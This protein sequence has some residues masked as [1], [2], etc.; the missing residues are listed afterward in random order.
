[1]WAGAW[2]LL[3]YNLIVYKRVWKGTA[4]TSFVTPLL[5]VV[6]MGVLLGGFVHVAPARLD[7]AP[8]YLAFIAPGLVASHAMTIAFSEMTYPVMGMVKWQK[9]YFS[10]IATPLSVPDL[11]LAHLAYVAFRVLTACGVFIAILAPFGVYRSMWGALV[12][13][14]AQMLVGLA[15]AAPVYAWAVGLDNEAPFSHLYRLGMVPLTLFSGAFFPVDNLGPALGWAARVTPLW[16]GVDLNRMLMLGTV[17]WPLLAV[18]VA[19]LGALVAL[20]W[21]LVLRRLQRRLIG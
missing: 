10:M 2:R 3:D 11:A 18:H 19:Y 20:G 6:A 21:W 7:G 16:H 1:M 17:S 15:F 4:V 12:A 9:I 5:T 8:T 14:P 13:V